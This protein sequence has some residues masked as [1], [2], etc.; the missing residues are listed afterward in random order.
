MAI[1][2][3]PRALADLLEIDPQLPS[4]SE[5]RFSG[6]GVVGLPFLSGHVLALWRVPASS[7]GYGFTSVWHRTPGGCWTFWS[8]VASDSSCGRFFGEAV[9]GVGIRPIRVAWKGSHALRVTVA[10]GL[11]DWWIGLRATPA[12]IA[13]NAVAGVVPAT[14]WRRAGFLRAAGRAVGGVLGVGRVGLTGKVPNGQRFVATPLRIWRIASGDARVG[15]VAL[16]PPGPLSEQAL[17]GDVA[18]PQGGIFAIGRA[19]V[20][21][22][23]PGRHS[24]VR[25]QAIETAAPGVPG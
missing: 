25:G 22:F 13:L 2:P 6:Y 17:L 8:D 21:P 11:V 18:I 20:E 4:G 7:L 5:E 10:D 9:A 12:T 23:N 24:S 1:L 15:Q 16:G 3:H 14:L 19:F